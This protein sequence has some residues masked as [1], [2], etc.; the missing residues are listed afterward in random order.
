MKG[1]KLVLGLSIGALGT[2]ALGAGFF[3]TQNSNFARVDAADFSNMTITRR[4]W[5]VNNADWWT[6]N[7]LYV[8]AWGG[9]LE[10]DQWSG[11]ASK[12]YDSYYHG[13]YYA[14]ITAKGIGSA[15][16][17]QIK[18]GDGSESDYYT[19]GVALPALSSKEADV[20]WMNSGK[21]GNGNRNASKGSAGGTSGFV[22]TIL[23]HELTCDASYA[24]GYNAYPQ[25]LV[26][27]ITPSAGEITQYGNQT[28]VDDF[29][30]ED[31]V[32]NGKSYE[33]IDRT[34]DLIN[35]NQKIDGLR[36]MYEEYGWK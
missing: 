6:T 5:F 13:L 21:D 19:C 22:A 17:V 33:D 28:M 10:T 27:F 15:I 9:S 1:I 30:Y 3:A 8:H 25:L 18:N 31:Y 14:D 35:L 12:I 32:E 11:V 36:S 34:E 26:D 4:I 16:N 23:E 24:Y 7:P 20:I 2:G 29:S